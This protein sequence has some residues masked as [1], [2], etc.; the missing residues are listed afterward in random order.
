MP[1]DGGVREVPKHSGKLIFHSLTRDADY[2]RQG[3]QACA[4]GRHPCRGE[5][6]H[7]K[8]GRDADATST[9]LEQTITHMRC[10]SFDN[11]FCRPDGELKFVAFMARKKPC[12]LITLLV[13]TNHYFLHK[14]PGN[15]QASMI[16]H[17]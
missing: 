9:R 3:G 4:Q 16:L 7:K 12:L 1:V 2:R 6:R 5:H 14:P 15:S 11:D 8:L 10:E 13:A 17:H